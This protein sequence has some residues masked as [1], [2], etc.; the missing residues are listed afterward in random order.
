MAQLVLQLL[1][2]AFVVLQDG[3]DGGQKGLSRV[4]LESRQP[5]GGRWCDGFFGFLGFFWAG[6]R[7]QRHALNVVPLRDLLFGFDI[8][9]KDEGRLVACV[10]GDFLLG[11]FQR[12]GC[13]DPHKE[14][15]TAGGVLEKEIHGWDVFGQSVT[16]VQVTRQ[17][18]GAMND[19]VSLYDMVS[20][21]SFIII[22]IDH[23]HHRQ[24]ER[25]R[26]QS[27]KYSP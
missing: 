13:G 8:V 3:L 21:A 17:T 22:I 16:E 4:H 25:T 6:G 14:T 27:Q 20:L 2:H 23:H 26:R 24:E 18:A 15:T 10:L 11:R 9:T 5:Q 7:G 19:T 1:L 12:A